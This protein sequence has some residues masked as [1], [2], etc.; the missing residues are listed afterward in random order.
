MSTVYGI[1]KQHEGNI[2]VYS[3]PD[4]GTTF[5]VYL[6]VVAGA[7]VEP[8][9][10]EKP[11]TGQAGSETILVVEDNKQVRL[12]ACNILKRQGYKLLLAENGAEALALLASNH[13]AVDLL[14]TDVVMPDINGR[15]LFAKVTELY[16]AV[17]VLYMSGYTN[18]V[19]AQRGVLDEGVSFIQKPFTVQGLAAKVREVLAVD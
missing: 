3:E 15:E 19:I 1:V 12:L 2:W 10:D 9:R 17:R 11:C 4:R 16:P 13:G 5:K 7:A 6:P 8:Q 14:L 18:D